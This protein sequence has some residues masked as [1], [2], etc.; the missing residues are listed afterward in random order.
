LGDYPHL[1]M[2]TKELT[3]DYERSHDCVVIVTDHSAY[4][5][6]W[7]VEHSTL[8]IDTRNA[9]RSIRGNYDKVVLA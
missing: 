1:R 2:S 6:A 9:A 7:V 4:D 5:C 8:I 3:T